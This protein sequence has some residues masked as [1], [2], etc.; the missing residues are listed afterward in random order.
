MGAVVGDVV[1]VSSR[2]RVRSI[3]STTGSVLGD[4]VTGAA[5]VITAP[6]RAILPAASTNRASRKSRATKVAPSGLIPDL[7]A[8]GAE[9]G[10]MGP[11]T[12]RRAKKQV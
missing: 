6:I 9:K 10:M 8:V 3:P 2:K 4:V 12:R 7:P 5:R 1:P 11:T